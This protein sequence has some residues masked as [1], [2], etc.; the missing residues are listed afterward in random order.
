MQKLGFWEESKGWKS[1]GNYSE[2]N[3]F[4][5][6]FGCN[7]RLDRVVQSGAKIRIKGAIDLRWL[8]CR[9]GAK[10]NAVEQVGSTALVSSFTVRLAG[11]CRYP[12][13]P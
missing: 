7:F 12:E 13:D 4:P 10:G 2:Y 9:F 3:F 1:L 6:V 11:F 8:G 5:C